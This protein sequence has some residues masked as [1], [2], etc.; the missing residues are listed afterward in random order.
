MA[1]LMSLKEATNLV[2]ERL[3]QVQLG[4]ILGVT[5]SQVYKYS[6]GDTK[7][8]KDSVVDAFYDN[9]WSGEDPI[10]LDFYDSEEEYLKYRKLRVEAEKTT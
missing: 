4:N 9:C 2:L 10:L 3:T 5:P 6:V 7:S 1:R 8:P